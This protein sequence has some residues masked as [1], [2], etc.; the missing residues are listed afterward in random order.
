MS[1]SLN[2]FNI[3][4]NINKNNSLIKILPNIFVSKYENDRIID[5]QNHDTHEF[6]IAHLSF[7]ATRCVRCNAQKQALRR[8]PNLS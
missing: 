4:N 3:V 6:A 8:I 5:F 1:H 2:I 7:V